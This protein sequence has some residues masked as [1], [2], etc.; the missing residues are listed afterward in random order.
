MSS[1]S[2][3]LVP[4]SHESSTLARPD[5]D[6]LQRNTEL[7]KLALESIAARQEG[8]ISKH[9]PGEKYFLKYS[10]QDGIARAAAERGEEVSDRIIQLT[11]QQIDPLEPA[12]HRLKK[13]MKAPPGAPPTILRDPNTELTQEERK[14]KKIPP[15]VSRWK[16][17]R[18]LLVTADQRAMLEGDHS[19][20]LS[21][22]KMAS[23]AD[24]LLSEERKLKNEAL[25]RS[26]V[27]QDEEPPLKRRGMRDDEQL[28]D[29][30]FDPRLAVKASDSLSA[31][32]EEEEEVSIYNK[33]LF[34]GRTAAGL[35]RPRV[36]T[37]E[38]AGV[39]AGETRA[40]GA[41]KI[42]FEKVD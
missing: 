41:G 6:S 27:E 7:T 9:K 40:L 20:D 34:E 32:V 17:N 26:R 11:E 8:R 24:A 42:E 29:T 36:V 1:H 35:Y 12:R 5:A 14:L 25:A 16:N 19:V 18:G 10:P 37:A 4:V 31:N 28:D 3:Q 23:F 2:N 21:A 38:R 30:E 13:S 15:C 39:G 22:N 33:S